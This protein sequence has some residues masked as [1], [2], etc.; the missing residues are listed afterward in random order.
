[1]GWGRTG[2]GL[3]GCKRSAGL[4]RRLLHLRIR[5]SHSLRGRAAG[6]SA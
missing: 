2:V 5:S 4:P 6:V 3:S 1:M